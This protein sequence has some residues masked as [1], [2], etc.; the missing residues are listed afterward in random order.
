MESKDL[1]D[2]GSRVTYIVVVIGPVESDL[3]ANFDV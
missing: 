2:T 1:Q 3:L